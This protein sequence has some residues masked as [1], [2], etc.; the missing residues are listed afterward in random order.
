MYFLFNTMKVEG[1]RVK[2]IFL[3]LVWTFKLALNKRMVLRNQE[4]IPAN[5]KQFSTSATDL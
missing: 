4:I 1:S 3:T 5:S 2:W